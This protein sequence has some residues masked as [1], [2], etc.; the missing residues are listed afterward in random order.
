MK[1]E[2][3]TVEA[4]AS[5]A[6][7][8][9]APVDETALATLRGNEAHDLATPSGGGMVALG[10]VTGEFTPRDFRPP[11]LKIV[12]G[13]GDLSAKYDPGCLV[14]A[15]QADETLLVKKSESL[16]LVLLGA[17]KFWK[18]W[19][20]SEA[21]NAGI[22]PRSFNTVKEVVAAGGTVEFGPAGERPTF[23]PAANF[24]VLIRQP[25]GVLSGLFS[26]DLNGHKYAIAKWIVDKTA[27]SRVGPTVFTAEATSLKDRGLASGIWE[28]HT[29]SVKS[30]NGRNMVITPFIRLAGH[31]TPAF[32]TE[33]KAAFPG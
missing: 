31:V 33:V 12:Y 10:A 8:E 17:H 16:T 5:V 14:M 29:E 3:K 24:T 9:T 11:Y 27:Y 13:V 32:L 1:Q 20:D 2:A 18:E 30:R 25:E 7:A 4:E 23:G 21:Y 6:P 22:F 19:Q 15:V 26:Y 28:L